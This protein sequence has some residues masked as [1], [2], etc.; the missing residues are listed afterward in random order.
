MNRQLSLTD[1]SVTLRSLQF[2]GAS[3]NGGGGLSCINSNVSAVYTWFSSF[4]QVGAGAGAIFV[5]SS[6]ITLTFSVL[7]SN[8]NTGSGAAGIVAMQGSEMTVESSRIEANEAYDAMQL[9][10][11]NNFLNGRRPYR[12]G[13][14]LADASAVFVTGS[15]FSHNR[16]GAIM[17]VSS[18]TMSVHNSLFRRNTE[19]VGFEDSSSAIAIRSGSIA[20]LASTLLQFNRASEGGAFEVSGTGSALTISLCNLHGN[21]AKGLQRSG[22]AIIVADGAALEV[23]DSGIADNVAEAPL[24]G[25]A[26]I[27][28]GGSITLTNVQLSRNV[29][30]DEPAAPIISGSGGIYSEETDLS[31]IGGDFRSNWAR[32][33]PNTDTGIRDLVS[34]AAADHLYTVSSGLQFVKSTNFQPFDDVQSAS[35]QPATYRG[36]LRSSCPEYPCNPGELCNYANYSLSCQRCSGKWVSYHGLQCE[37]CKYVHNQSAV[38]CD[39]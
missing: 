32:T 38:A 2:S 30:N 31:I 20:T 5:E 33:A 29:L 6:R 8:V 21:R 36:S 24:A 12:T 19:A 17:L 14:I 26:L 37:A 3:V 39:V 28:F 10:E 7:E 22:G 25:G 11:L 1:A 16:G 9:D 13:G 4:E 15:R 35:Y 23:L 34:V 18:S 27:S